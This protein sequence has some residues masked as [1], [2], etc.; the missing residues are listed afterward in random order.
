MQELANQVSKLLTENMMI[1]LRSK[2]GFAI[3]KDIVRPLV[4]RADNAIMGALLDWPH[5]SV[6][7]FV[8][9]YERELEFFVEDVVMI[10]NLTA[11]VVR[12]KV[13]VVTDE[14]ADK[15][16]DFIQTWHHVQ[17]LN[18][19]RLHQSVVRNRN[20]RENNHASRQARNQSG[21]HFTR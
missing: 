8:D 19:A 6:Y 4:A 1:D 10:T 9:A 11:L 16:Y 13:Q 12:E 3:P 17:R 7:G 14:L 15:L 2:F 20:S 21:R 18:A 5:D